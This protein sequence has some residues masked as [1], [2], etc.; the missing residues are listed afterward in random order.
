LAAGRVVV[1]VV[2]V[3]NSCSSFV[4]RRSSFVVRL[5]W[6]SLVLGAWCLVLG[7]F[8]LVLFLR[9]RCT[10]KAECREWILLLP[11]VVEIRHFFIS[12]F[13]CFWHATSWRAI[14]GICCVRKAR[15]RSVARMVCEIT[16]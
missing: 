10:T 14:L 11:K 8:C 4:V 7:V 15:S 3:I 1:V 13:F 2:I 6:C 9:L 16:P 12:S 5:A